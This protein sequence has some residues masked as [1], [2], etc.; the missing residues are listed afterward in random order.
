MRKRLLVLALTLGVP[1]A[2]LVPYAAVADAPAK[3][4]PRAAAERNDPENTRA[5]SQFMETVL[6]GNAKLAAGDAAAAIDLYKKAAQLQSKDALAPYLLGE[7]YLASANLPEAEAAWKHAEELADGKSPLRGHVLFV[8]AD[9]Y[10]R[11]KKWEPARAAWKTYAEY[12]QSRD[13]GVH[14]ASAAARLKAID[15]WLALD[16]KYELVRQR[17]AADKDGGADASAPAPK[18]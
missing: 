9:V 5:I 4:R 6:L 13:G 17:I 12:A 10:E 14:P 7:A 16:Q 11:Q 1:A 3:P 2:A 15:E 8:L 18:K